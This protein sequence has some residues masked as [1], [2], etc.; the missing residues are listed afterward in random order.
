MKLYVICDS[1][2]NVTLQYEEGEDKGIYRYGMYD[3]WLIVKMLEDIRNGHLPEKKDSEPLSEWLT[4][5][6]DPAHKWFM[7]NT[8]EEVYKEILLTRPDF[9]CQKR[10]QECVVSTLC[11]R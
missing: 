8:P 10:L 6:P 9:T 4:Y 3:A 7:G 11:Q 2:Q 5:R 1:D